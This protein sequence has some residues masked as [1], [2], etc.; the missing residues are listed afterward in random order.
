MRWVILLLFLPT[1]LAWG[2]DTHVWMCEEIYNSNKELQKIIKNKTLFLEG[3]NAPDNVISDQHLHN[4]YYARQCKKIDTSKKSPATLHYFVDVADCFD[5]KFFS[6]PALDKFNQTLKA[7]AYSIGMAI[8]YISDAY[9]PLHQVTGEDYFSCHKPFED[10]V[11]ASIKRN[12]WFARQFCTFSFPCFKARN[13]IRKCDDVYSETIEFSY[14]DLV[15]VVV[16]ID[17]EI[18]NRL[19]INKGDYTHLIKT[20]MFYRILEKLQKIFQNLRLNF[21]LQNIFS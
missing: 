21:P 12:N 19:N 13:S 2:F 15:N 18:S 14:S 17:E 5:G 10:K 8:H 20:G 11:D 3:C 9:N 6:C 16:K 1:V 7:D 4:C